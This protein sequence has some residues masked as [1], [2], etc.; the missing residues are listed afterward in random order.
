MKN[1]L[2]NEIIFKRI[3]TLSF[4]DFCWNWLPLMLIWWTYT[5]F[6]SATVAIL[7]KCLSSIVETRVLWWLC[8]SLKCWVCLKFHL[9]CEHLFFV[10]CR[11]RALFWFF[12]LSWSLSFIFVLWLLNILVHIC[13]S[14]FIIKFLTIISRKII[15][16]PWGSFSIFSF[17]LCFSSTQYLYDSKV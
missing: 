7:I 5:K 8:E 17:R 2:R 16:L 3:M 9:G 6:I 14:R 10:F 15:C 13:I 1:R 11:Q 12:L 4:F